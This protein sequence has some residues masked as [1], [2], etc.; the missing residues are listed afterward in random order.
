MSTAPVS[1]SGHTPASCYLPPEGCVDAGILT[2]VGNQRALPDSP[3][4]ARRNTSYS[5]IPTF[6]SPSACSALVQGLKE[7][8]YLPMHQNKDYCLGCREMPSPYP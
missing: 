8:E 2:L 3:D 5:V 6:S 4:C 7:E 1:T